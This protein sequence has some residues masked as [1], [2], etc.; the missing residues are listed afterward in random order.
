MRINREILKKTGF[1]IAVVAFFIILSYAFVPRVLKGEIVNQGDI[2]GY[3]GMSHEMTEWNKA[4]PD[5]P[6]YW[7]D[8]MFGGMPTTAI[9]NQNKGDLTQWIYNFLLTGKRPATYL[10]IALLGGFLL[11]LAFGVSWPLAIGGAIAI[12]FCSYNFQI[13]QVGHNTKMQAIAF[14]PWVLAA[15]VFTYKSAFKDKKW[16]PGTLLGSSLFAFAL[17]F[18]IKANHPQITYYL[19][20]MVVLYALALLVDIL[21]GKK[22]RFKRFLWASLMLLGFGLVGIATNVNKLL[23]LY[24]YTP[25][26]MR[27]G[28][29]LSGEGVNSTGLSLD[30][31]T[32]WS[33]G[34]NEL[35]NLMIPNYNGGASAEP[36]DPDRSE[37]VRLLKKSG[38]GAA[39]RDFSKNF[40]GYWGPQQFTAGPMYM[41]AITVFLFVLGLCLLKGRDKWWLA[42]VTLIAVL[43]GVGSHFMP[44]TKF[45]FKVLP[46]YEKFRTVSMAL[47]LLQVTLPLLGFVVLDRI[48]RGEFPA[49]K[50]KKSS[51]IA[52]ALTGGFCLLMGLIPSLAGDFSSASDSGLPAVFA[53]AIKEDRALLLRRD[54]LI[55][56][57]LIFV[58]FAVIFWSLSPKGQSDHARAFAG[59]G[60]GLFGA[61]AISILVLANMFIVGKRYLNSSHFTTEKDF[62]KVFAE[63]PVDKIIKADPAPSYRVLDLTVNVFNSSVPSYHHKNIGGY[64]P[65]KLQRYQDL[66]THYISP[67]INKI[68]SVLNTAGNIE[69]AESV[70]ENTPVLNALNLKYTVLGGDFPPLVNAYGLGNAWFVGESVCARNPDEEIAL[71]GQVDLY[72]EAVFAEK[73]V[74]SAAGLPGIGSE[75]EMTEY[76]PNCLKYHYKTDKEAIAIFSEVWYPGWTATIDAGTEAEQTTEVLRADW[77][78]RAAVLPA[79]EHELVMRF[80]PEVY[81][82]GAAVSRASSIALILLALFSLGLY[83]RKPDD[84]RDIA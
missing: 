38:Q 61:I 39:A 37:T 34:W 21:I 54:S 23:P 10:F 27:G 40:P 67:E 76:A 60:R 55:S 41:G 47:V 43:M 51:W 2:S 30:Y 9:S 3:L 72:S 48:F 35:P 70:F 16:L 71:I 62:K 65:A 44:F 63:R 32:A 59:A 28:S 36:I 24:E 26:T 84:E 82:R 56:F 45:C 57:V 74:P 69:D 13:I 50:V 33:Y 7:T 78:L 11:M 4:H 29:E 68:Y 1:A 81:R 83:F 80:E 22:A 77:T 20:I 53:E 5:D 18:Q 14:M 73:D 15:F 66:I 19:A 46:M 31:A 17:S 64:S 79:G 49:A 8:S 12:A 75:I 6:T 42:A 58:S 25:Y 52:L